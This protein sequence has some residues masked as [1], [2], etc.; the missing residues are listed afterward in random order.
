MSKRSMSPER[1]RKEKIRKRDR[2]YYVKAHVCQMEGCG[3]S[4]DVTQI[5]HFCYDSAGYDPKNFIEV[6]AKCHAQI[7]GFLYKE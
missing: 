6:C 2:K 3:K 7:H 5:H 1:K 4:C